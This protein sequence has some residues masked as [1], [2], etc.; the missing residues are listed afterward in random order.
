[1]K[2]FRIALNIVIILIFLG[3]LIT[4]LTGPGNVS[5]LFGL[6]M[7]TSLLCGP[8]AATLYAIRT[9]SIAVLKLTKFANWIVLGIF[10]LL[11]AL[12]TTGTGGN[13]AILPLAAIVIGIAYSNILLIK[14]SMA[15]IDSQESSD[16]RASY[17]PLLLA[18]ADGNLEEVSRL[19]AE[20]AQVDSR[21]P[22][23]ETALILAARNNRLECVERLLSAGADKHAVTK[24]NSSAEAVA[25]RF[26]HSEILAL[27]GGWNNIGKPR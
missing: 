16:A 5:Y 27:L 4:S 17:P 7:G 2:K 18:A 22:A 20:G 10:A 14:S 11:A 24:K 12:M 13:I 1:M 3:A 6:A 23:G 9:N 25:R 26:G 8:F 15:E 21:G 19:L